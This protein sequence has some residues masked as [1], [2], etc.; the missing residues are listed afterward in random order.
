MDQSEFEAL[1]KRV[2]SLDIELKRV[3]RNNMNM[4][5]AKQVGE[6]IHLALEKFM[7][8][9]NSVLG[10]LEFFREYRHLYSVGMTLI[11]KPTAATDILTELKYLWE[12]H[13]HGPEG[14]AA[15]IEAIV[16]E[17]EMKSVVD[18]ISF[19]RDGW[20]DWVVSG[21]VTRIKDSE[22]LEMFR[23]WKLQRKERDDV[24]PR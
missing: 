21:E 13:K 18:F 16:Q 9:P 22:L 14:T 12:G 24:Q 4:F 1:N 2:Q 8:A 7:N 6:R 15:R 10:L 11:P 20:D 23:L 19:L 17:R 5:G 3:K